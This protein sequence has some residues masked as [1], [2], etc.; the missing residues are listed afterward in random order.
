MCLPNA[1]TITPVIV[2]TFQSGTKQLK[3]TNTS[4]RHSIVILW[5]GIWRESC[6]IINESETTCQDFTRF[7][8]LCCFLNVWKHSAVLL[9][10]SWWIQIYCDHCHTS[11]SLT[12]EL[13]LIMAFPPFHFFFSKKDNTLNGACTVIFK[14]LAY[15]LQ[16]QQYKSAHAFSNLLQSNIIQI[17]MFNMFMF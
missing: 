9:Y 7:H 8:T 16:F 11:S 12:M 17:F 3:N 15:F 2:K 10:L 5:K 4:L 14:I 1:P 13:W 6:Q